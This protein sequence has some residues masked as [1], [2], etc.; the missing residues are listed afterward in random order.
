MVNLRIE[1]TDEHA[2]LL[3]VVIRRG[4]LATKRLPG[5]PQDAEDYFEQVADSLDA[6]TGDDDDDWWEE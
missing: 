6:A 2:G 1:L 5:L 4:V 3:A